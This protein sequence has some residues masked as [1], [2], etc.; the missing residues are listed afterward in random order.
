M[1]NGLCVAILLLVCIPQFVLS[2]NCFANT[3]QQIPLVERGQ[4]KY[5]TPENAIIAFFSANMAGDIDWY[6]Q[7]LTT[8]SM[9]QEKTDFA[10]NNLDPMAEIDVFKK[11][12]SKAS[13][14]NKFT[15]IDS[16]VIL[17]QITNVEGDISELPYTLVQEEGLWKITNKYSDSEELLQYFKYEPK[18]FYGH[19]QR[20]ADVNAFL[21]YHRPQKATST[22]SAGEPIFKLHIFYGASIVPSTFSATLEGQD[23]SNLFSPIP[24]SD[25]LVIVNLRPGKNVLLLSVDGKR[26]DGKIATDSDR[27]VFIV[28]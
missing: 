22:L 23:V 13:I 16:T 8:S 1:R 28:P 24:S 4:E 3:A 17:V 7:T 6:Y 2:F 26:A 9:E 10:I 11:A 15:Y 19:G 25:Q 14:V 20:P 21:A 12:F 27:L 18:L 5:D